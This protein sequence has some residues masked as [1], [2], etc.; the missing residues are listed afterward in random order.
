MKYTHLLH[1]VSK[2]E[3]F[4]FSFGTLNTS[5]LY[6]SQATGHAPVMK[7]QAA[8][9]S[10]PDTATQRTVRAHNTGRAEQYMAQE[11]EIFMLLSSIAGGMTRQLI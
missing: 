3:H 10:S 7:F 6:T 8:L 5:S 2:T 11:V 9:C 1:N 4:F